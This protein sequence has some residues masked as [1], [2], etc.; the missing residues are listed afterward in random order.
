VIE[1]AILVYLFMKN[2]KQAKPINNLEE[3][4]PKNFEHKEVEARTYKKWEDSGVFTPEKDSPAPSYSIILPPPNANGSLHTGHAMYVVEDILCRWKRLKGYNVLWLPGADHAGFET[5]YVFENELAKQKKS[6]FD[7]D[8]TTLY[9]KIMEFVQDQRFTMYDQMKK[10]GFSLDWTR[11]KFTLNPDLVDRVYDAFIKMYKDGFI[12]RDNYLVNYS[13]AFGSTFSDLEITHKE[14]TSKL[15][16]IKYGPITVATVRPETIFGDVAIAVNSTDKRYKAYVGKTIEVEIPEM[17]LSLKVIADDHVDPEFGT[18]ALKITPAHSADDFEIAKR[19]KLEAPQVIGLDGKLNEKTGKY[20]GMKIGEARDAVVEDLQKMGLMEKI[21]ENYVHNIVVDYKDKRPIEPTLMPNWFVK[22]ADLAKP[23][24]EAVK[25]GRVVL[26]PKRAEKVFFNWME[27]IRDWPISRQIVWGIRIPAWYDVTQNPDI[28]VTFI[29]DKGKQK[30]GR[31]GEMLKEGHSLKEINKGLQSLIAPNDSKFVIS[32]EKP[33]DMFLQETDT[34]DTWFSSGQWPL[35]TLGYPD[36]A[37][38]KKFYPTDVLDTGSDILFFWVARMIM[39]GLYLVDEVPFKHVYLHAMVT[40]KTGLKMSKSKGNVINPLEVI[41]VYGADALRM[42]L[43][44]GSSAGGRTSISD[45]KFKGFRNFVNKMWNATRFIMM[46]YDRV[47]EE[48]QKLTREKLKN[49]EE[50]GSRSA[51]FKKVKKLEEST[52]EKL[53]N[54]RFSLAAE[55]LHSSFWGELC[56]IWIEE[57]KTAVS[58]DA[59]SDETKAEKLAELIYALTRH[60]RMLHPFIPFITE[61]LWGKLFALGLLETE[62]LQASK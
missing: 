6:R 47:G 22:I 21:D 15:Y 60:L 61:E 42:S 7:F 35:T 24:I 38:F 4:F 17:T 51:W 29:D 14:K 13:P 25:K 55:E 27:N 2:V 40:D 56:D 33:G 37:D 58:D 5:Q 20:A 44:V 18:G 9:D 1:S 32:K 54:F 12:Y 34:L 26:H 46:N 39:F 16:Y 8:R 57:T 62:S 52:D 19:H 45:E 3:L 48:T 11:E 36:G 28:Q 59:V 49:I 43:I 31:V 53:E 10:L 50:K 23:A 30:T 41:D